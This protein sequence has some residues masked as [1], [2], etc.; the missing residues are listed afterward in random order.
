VFIGKK[1]HIAMMVLL[2]LV[3]FGT[4]I[5]DQAFAFDLNKGADDALALMKKIVLIV[6]LV[7]ATATF[8]K[9]QMVAA[10]VIVIVGSIILA[11]TS[12][13][14]LASIGRGL[15]NLVGGGS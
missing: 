7:S 10:V 3:V 11:T 8:L 1:V 15:L 12:L 5:P 13:D 14:T 2:L 9:H 4:V 6:M